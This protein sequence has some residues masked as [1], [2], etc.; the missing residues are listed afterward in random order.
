MSLVFTWTGPSSGP[1]SSV[2]LGLRPSSPALSKGPVV[3]WSSFSGDLA[4]AVS[5]LPDTISGESYVVQSSSV[6]F[7]VSTW[8]SQSRDFLVFLVCFISI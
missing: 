6:S 2:V 7:S 8:S 4:R 3:L 5:F 1:C